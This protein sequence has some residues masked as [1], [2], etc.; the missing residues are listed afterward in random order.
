MA[1][2]DYYEVLGVSRSATTVEIKAAYRNMA[3]KCHPDLH[4]NDKEAEIQ[5]NGAIFLENQ[6]DAQKG[7]THISELEVKC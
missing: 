1:K 6:L 3:K 4:P 2:K 5:F 7:V